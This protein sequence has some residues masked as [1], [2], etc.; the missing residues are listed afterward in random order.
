M[1]TK[2][3]SVKILKFHQFILINLQLI[4]Q[5][6]KN[7][8]K[9]TLECVTYHEASI[10]KTLALRKQTRQTDFFETGSKVYFKRNI[11]QKWRCP[12]IVISQDG[13]IVFNRL[14]GLL[15]KVQSSRTQT[16]CDFSLPSKIDLQSKVY[17]I[18]S[19]KTSKQIFTNYL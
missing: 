18:F 3:Y 14:G 4:F 7:P 15:Y 19:Q 9:K 8:E 17:V 13:A 6:K 12:G 1:Y 5:K 11:D 2:L 16:I 10:E